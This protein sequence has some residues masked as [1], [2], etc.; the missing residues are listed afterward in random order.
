VFDVRVQFAEYPDVPG[1]PAFDVEIASSEMPSG[2]SWLANCLLELGVPLWK[3]WGADIRD[4]WRACGP[5]R[6]RYAS[7][8]ENWRRLLPSLA[9]G[10][11]FTFRAAPVPRMTHAWAG[12]YGDVPR[13]ILMVRDPR[14]ALH[15]F[16]HRARRA[17][18]VPETE[19]FAT[20]VHGAWFHYPV[21]RAE[22]LLLLLRTWRL[23]LAGREHLVLRFEDY[24]RDA[25]GTLRR[26]LGFLGIDATDADVSR[27]LAASDLSAAQAAEQ[28]LVA[29]GTLAATFNRAGLAEEW[30]AAFDTT[31]HAAVGPRYASLYDW[32]GYAPDESGIAPPPEP[33]PS[34][35]WVERLLVAA[36]TRAWRPERAARLR[37]RLIAAS[38]D[39]TSV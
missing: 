18:L 7:A 12:T 30:R 6:F 32:L 13:T 19:D 26:A 1:F 10:R 15:S 23:A 28:Q 39:R 21:S 8:D 25:E 20:F 38:M 3:P 11:E 24:R 4:H 37:E 14:D 33:E 34:P 31:M 27:A 17:G 9:D 36:D 29:D 35:E 22:Y 5:R 16:W 2:S